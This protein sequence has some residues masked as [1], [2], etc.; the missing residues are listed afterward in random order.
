AYLLLQH[1]SIPVQNGPVDF[2]MLLGMA[3]EQ[4]EAVRADVGRLLLYTPVVHPDE[5]D[6]AISYLVRRLEEGASDDNFMSAV[7]K[8]DDEAMLQREADRFLASLEQRKN[9]VDCGPEPRR[10]QNRQ[11]EDFSAPSP[12]A[13][14]NTADSDPDLPANRDWGRQ[15]IERMAT[16]QLGQTVVKAHRIETE[17]QLDAA[18]TGAQRAGCT[19]QDLPLS[20]RS[21]ILIRIGD[22]LAAVRGQLIEV[23]GAETGKTIDQSDPEVSEAIDFAR[24]YAEQCRQLD[25]LPGARAHPVGL[26]VVTPPWNFP[27][28]IPTGSVVSALAAGSP[29]MF[30]PAPQAQ[31]TAAVIVQAIW[32]ALDEFEL[33]R[34]LVQFVIA[35]ESTIGTSLVTDRRAER[36]ILTG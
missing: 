27:L 17:A 19:W 1:R 2:E 14:V 22:H 6:V 28:A 23:M 20:T 8:L 9:E 25:Q 4:A 24:F 34:E 29:V 15:I 21:E 30:K 7:F 36:V 18:I 12:Q 16:S 13:F 10:N 32:A 31:R 3:S 33:S 26:T 11:T 35:E 5:F